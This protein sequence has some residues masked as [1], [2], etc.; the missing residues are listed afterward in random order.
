MSPVVSPPKVKDGEIKFLLERLCTVAVSTNE[1]EPPGLGMLNEVFA[2][3]IWLLPLVRVNAEKMGLVET[4]TDVEPPRFTV[5]P[6][7]MLLPAFIVIELFAKA[8]SGI[9]V[10]VLFPPERV[11]L[12]NVWL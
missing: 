10:N 6:P 1:S 4:D 11:L 9:L 5:P 2:D 3:I 8:E 12:V 7:I